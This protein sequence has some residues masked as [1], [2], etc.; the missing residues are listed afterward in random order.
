[1]LNA[2]APR[3][4]AVRAAA[5]VAAP[6][7]LPA[8]AVLLPPNLKVVPPPPASDEGTGSLEHITPRTID[9][10]SPKATSSGSRGVLIAL[11]GG[12]VRVVTLRCKVVR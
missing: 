9:A 2:G 10:R 12:G 6:V 1:V 7:R 4:P 11:A 3:R 5:R 8:G